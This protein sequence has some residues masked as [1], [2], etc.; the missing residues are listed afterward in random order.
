MHAAVMTLTFAGLLRTEHG[1]G[2]FVRDGKGDAD[3]SL[4][5][6]RANRSEL[7]GLRRDLELA[8]G[9]RAARQRT[10]QDLHRLWVALSELRIALSSEQ[11]TWI[12]DADFALHAALVRAAH[13]TFLTSVHRALGK[14]LHPDLAGH[15]GRLRRN[16]PIL[17][18]HA[19]ILDA[20]ES[21]RPAWIASSL[22]ATLSA[23]ADLSV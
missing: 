23:E 17:D 12:A 10:E 21:R 15:A 5:I 6:R 7:H 8:A 4:A 13:N 19:R 2:T 14:R 1:V 3:L 20:L 18:Q 22:A 9:A 11:A 16:V